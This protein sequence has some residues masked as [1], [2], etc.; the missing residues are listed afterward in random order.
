MHQDE[1][2]EGMTRR[3]HRPEG[4]GARGAQ[5]VERANLWGIIL[6][7]GSGERLQPFLRRCGHPHPIKQYCA[8]IGRRTMLQHT[9]ERVQRL[10]PPERVLTVVDAGHARVFHGQLAD[11]P[12]GSVIHQPLNL[13]TAP[14]TLL[15]LAHVLRA[16]PEAVVCLFPADHFVLEERL[17]MARVRVA[18]AAVQRRLWEFVVLGVRPQGPDCDYGWIEVDRSSQHLGSCLLPVQAFHEKPSESAARSLYRAGHLWSTMV[19]VA[20]AASLW[21]LI[22]STQPALRAPFERIRAAVGT[23]AEQQQ[24]GNAYLGLPR[25]SLS[26]GVL[27]RVPSRLGVLA[28]DG[29]NW[30]DWGRE[31]RVMETLRRLEEERAPSANGFGAVAHGLQNGLEGE[32]R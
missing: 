27:E 26:K 12:A 20:R 4:G 5:M 7:A 21:D 10:I 25:I 18:E 15:P 24:V 2:A 32:E 9:W 16:D 13:E 3:R 17:F 22:T 28:V 8:I 30:S 1:V 11:R 29:V 19:I 23:P 6:A 14:G 31:E